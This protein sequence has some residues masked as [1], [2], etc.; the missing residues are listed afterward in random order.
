MQ[1]II[2]SSSDAS[3]CCFCSC[4]GERKNQSVHL[5][6]SLSHVLLCAELVC[7]L[8]AITTC[9]YVRKVDVRNYCSESHDTWVTQWVF[10]LLLSYLGAASEPRIHVQTCFTS[11]LLSNPSLFR[12]KIPLG[13]VCTCVSAYALSVLKEACF[14]IQQ[15]LKVCF[16]WI[17]LKSYHV[18][19][20]V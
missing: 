17:L 15:L 20:C 10:C 18:I 16:V 7:S 6:V 19:L 2:S 14:L 11:V 3:V 12:G 1:T 5:K 4:L 9:F 13:C 8:L